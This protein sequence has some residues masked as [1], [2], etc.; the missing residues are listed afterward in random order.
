MG[1]FLISHEIEAK[2]LTAIIPF[3]LKASMA[4]CH[5]NAD[6]LPAKILDKQK[7]NSKSWEFSHN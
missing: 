4:W 2:E 6:F 5:E 3:S 7:A 1:N